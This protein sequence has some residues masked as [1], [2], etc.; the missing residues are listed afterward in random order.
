[1]KGSP[2]PGFDLH[3]TLV[4]MKDE[5]PR[6]I[7]LVFRYTPGWTLAN[8][9]LM[10][11]LGLLPLASL[12]IIKLLVDTVTAG[13]AAPDKAAVSQELFLFIFAAVIIALLTSCFRAISAYVNEVQ[14]LELTDGI[15]DLVH[16]QSM[17]LDLA[18]YENPVYQDTLH[19]AQ[20][21]SSSRPGKI[22]NDLVQIVQ[23]CIS[24]AAVGALIFSFSVLAG[25]ILIG[26]AIPAMVVRVWYTRKL[27]DLNLGQTE[28]IRKS[29][30]YHVML[31]HAHY[32]KE[33]RLFSLGPFFR[34]LYNSTQ[35][36]TRFSKLG[37]SRSKA[38]WDIVTQGLVTAAVF[39]SFTVI[40]LMTLRGEMSLGDMVM[41]FMG[42]QLCI[43]YIQTIF[44]GITTLYDDHLFLRDFF[45]FLDTTPAIAAPENPVPLPDNPVEEIRLDS[46]SFT[47]PG[48]QKPALQDIS[49]SIKKGE[50]IAFVG[51]NGAG[52]STLVKLL[53]RLYLPDTG[54][55]TVDGVDIKSLDPEAWRR[56]LS[57]LFQDYIR[58]QL[59]VED[60]IRVGDIERADEPGGIE[61]SAKKAGA[62]RM[63]QRF[64]DGYK[65][66]L[67]KLFSGGR[68]LST[69]EWQKIALSRAFFRDAELI[70][71]DEPASSLDALAESEIF[72]KFKEIIR[73][74]TA[75]IISHRFSTVRMAD[76]IYVIEEGRIIE[77]G[78]HADLMALNGQYAEMFSAQADLYISQ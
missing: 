9:I 56:R 59:T 78:S 8:I 1:M 52:K 63:I 46:I 26:S 65:T 29:A 70:L 22:V 25:I 50:V 12:Y 31:T 40:A 30:Y 71:L 21:Q 35:K 5:I 77:Q 55:I 44:S 42:F 32:A 62:D 51:E 7:R 76:R 24:L 74:R 15:T 11:I 66:M 45:Q 13:I 73:E 28:L 39:G 37:I 36:L 72:R 23:N 17:A 57:V 4:S 69:G 58:Y 48:A 60:N 3:D 10:F 6:A 41:Y 27:Y 68:E 53:C 49:M 18:Y 33:N 19:R 16:T 54:T 14:S 2:S 38:I 75:V 67:G 34:G 43:G 47:Y 20:T 61:K 64:P